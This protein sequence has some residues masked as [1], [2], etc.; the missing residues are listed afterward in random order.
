MSLGIFCGR[1]LAIKI[2]YSTLWG[3][4]EVEVGVVFDYTYAKEYLK[5]ECTFFKYDLYSQLLKS[6]KITL[7]KFT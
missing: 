4:F 5:L 2:N 1:F 6:N 3:I 7:D